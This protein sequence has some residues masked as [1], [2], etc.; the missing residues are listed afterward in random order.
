MRT[1][2]NTHATSKKSIQEKHSCR[3]A[4]LNYLVYVCAQSIIRLWKWDL[5][6]TTAPRPFGVSLVVP[7]RKVAAAALLSL[8]ARRRAFGKLT[9][10][11]AAHGARHDVILE[12]ALVRRAESTRLPFAAALARKSASANDAVNEFSLRV[13][14]RTGLQTYTPILTMAVM[15]H[16]SRIFIQ[17][18]VAYVF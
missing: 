3:N 1:T 11:A 17:L 2:V 18:C 8:T 12:P 5:V 9:A 13:A 15:F 7:V 4:N 16:L 10:T 6:P 14:P